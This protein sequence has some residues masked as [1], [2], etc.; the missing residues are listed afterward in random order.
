MQKKYVIAATLLFCFSLLTSQFSLAQGPPIP[1]RIGGRLTVNN[2]QI[3]KGADAGYAIVITRQDGTAFTPAAEDRDGLSDSDWYQADIPIYNQSTQP[4]GAE[5]GSTALIHVYKDGSE[6]TVTSPAGGR[7][8]VGAGAS[9]TQIDISAVSAA[10]NQPP[11]A[12]AGPAQTVKTGETVTLDGSASG[13][14]DDGIVS[15]QW[16]QISGAGVTL[17]DSASSQPKFTA[18][19]V[20]GLLIFELTVKDRG[21][22]S[23]TDQVTITVSSSENK[24]P[25]ADAGPN[26]SVKAGQRVS[27]D[28]SGSGDADDGI[29]SYQWRQI[30]GAGVTLSDSAGSQ[31][32]FTAPSAGGQMIFELTVTDR[33]G[34]TATDQVT[35]TVS[36]ENKPPVADAGPN[37]SV[38]AG[39]SVRLDGSASSDPDDGIAAYLWRQIG[40]LGVTLSDSAVSQPEF[41]APNAGSAGE[42]LIFRLTV[43]DRGGLTATDQVTVTVTWENRPP[44]AD[45]G[46]NQNVKPGVTVTLD[47]SASADS[48][49]GIVSCQ[50]R[51]VS[52]TSVKLSDA[53]AVRATFTAPDVGTGGES[54]VF[55]LTVRDKSGLSAAA[56]VTVNVI[57]ENMPPAADAGADRSVREGETVT[58]DGAGSGDPDDGIVSYQWRQISGIGVTL[59]DSSGIK[60]NF[61]APNVGAG[62][63]SLIFRLTVTDRSGLTDSDDVTVN[64]THGNQ[65]PRADAG[66]DQTVRSGASV[67]LDGSQSADPDGQI[68]AYSWRQTAGTWVN[69]SDPAVRQPKFAA[70]EVS[71]SGESLTFELTVS[72]N[73]GLSDTDSVTVNVIAQNQPPTAYAGA[74]QTVSAGASVMLDASG[75]SDPDDGIAA[76]L[77]RQTDGTVVK[78]SDAGAVKPAF[79][80]P[81]AGGES[82]TFEVTV[83]D[84]LGLSDTDSV[85]VNVISQNQPPTAYAGADQ[86]VSAGASVMLD[87]SGSSDPDDG[88][89]AYLWRQTDGA[90]VKLSDAGAAKPAFTAPDTGNQSLTF[91]LTVTDKSELSRSDSVTVS[92]ISQ[93]QAPFAS[94]GPDQSVKQGK[95]VTLDG[96]NSADPDGQIVSYF[97]RQTGGTAVKLSDVSAVRPTFA[98]SGTGNESLTF[99]LT[100]TDDRG[101]T[102]TATVRVNV[103]W[104]NLPP[105]AEAGP[106]Q[107]VKQ[108]TA[109]T[110]DGSNSSDADGQIVS[111]AWKQISGTRV[112]LSDPKGKQTVFTAS[113][114]G[115]S[116]TALTF[117]LTVTDSGGLSA[118]DRVTVNVTSENRPPSADAGPDQTVNEGDKVILDGSNSSDPDG[119]IVS[120]LWR[121]TGGSIMPISDITSVQARFTAS[122][123]DLRGESLVFELTVTDSGGLQHT[124]RITVNIS[125]GNMPPSAN[126][127]PDQTVREGCLVMLNGSNSGDADDGIAGYQ[128]RQTGGDS[129]TLSDPAAV[130]PT[131]AAPEVSASGK[132]LSFELTVTDKGGL[133]ATDTLTVNISDINQPPSADA[134]PVQTVNEGEQVKLDGSGSADPDGE[135]AAYLWTQTSGPPVTLSDPGDPA[136]EFAAPRVELNSGALTFR[137]TVTDDGG[138]RDTDRVAVN[139]TLGNQTPRASAGGAQT[140]REGSTVW[141][142]GSASDDPDGHIAGY[143]WRQSRGAAVTLSDAAE[144]RTSFVTPATDPRGMTLMFEL[145]VTDNGGLKDTD[146][147][148]VTIYDNGITAFS[149]D[150]I[151][152]VSATDQ[153]M[154]IKS[155]MGNITA[156]Y[157]RDARSFAETSDKPE[158]MLYGLTELEIRTDR[159]GDRAAVF[160]YLPAPAPQSSKWYR[161]SRAGSWYDYSG[162]SS[163]STDRKRVTLSFDDGGLGDN[164]GQADRKIVSISGLGVPGEKDDDSPVT[165]PSAESGGGDSNCFISTAAE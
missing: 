85:T 145:T 40:G 148:S 146:E 134:G 152:F 90:V 95:P 8:T 68:V 98:A 36:S 135:I 35:V 155:S 52:G 94:A 139:I 37:Q 48:D 67:M 121:Q 128:W 123:G 110:L 60:T 21:G 45:A 109:V 101:L 88:I 17:S 133:Q 25:V 120:Y 108:G 127:G 4:G 41:K 76:Y 64:I 29:V 27:L 154:G 58:L 5:P 47:A 93:N 86:T 9:V 73:L 164:D 78:L 14:P 46:E 163:F 87:A 18:P 39:Q 50:W 104:G 6:M 132:S 125:A 20:A 13:D 144:A 23:A 111:Y 117:E 138:L 49:D 63:E 141:L 156:L 32:S 143:Q 79:T 140:V 81:A 59:S 83:T 44:V 162:N 159:A 126:A 31:P 122:N 7:L 1:A 54:L 103:I 10:D 147:I 61:T 100:V 131:F 113:D 129:V 42:T 43:T 116:A 99:E 56:Q 92:V 62:G 30:G 158:E 19:A 119:H 57:A 22:L 165:N 157:V 142:E 3:K 96:S 105:V 97:W 149:D 28:G 130:Q 34:L 89:A 33:G 26:Q 102:D 51:Q 71:A 53:A 75:S 65:A 11:S 66:E 124:D 80:A 15:Y 91:E 153:L 77:W 72:D 118:A 115:M 38:K 24:P 69:L 107:T 2:V 55:E 12:D 114:G 70:P 112:S 16:R 161:Y 106:D 150:V 84:S 160:V 151:S 74:D 136:P 82:L 137:L